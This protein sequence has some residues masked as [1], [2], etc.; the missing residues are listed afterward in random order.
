MYYRLLAAQLLPEDLDRV[1]YLDPDVLIINP[2]E[3]LWSLGLDENLFA[4]AAH[5]GKTEIANNVKPC[6]VRG[7]IGIITIPA[8]C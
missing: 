4:A 2:L 3:K 6:P 8:Y 5:T 1:L 7:Q